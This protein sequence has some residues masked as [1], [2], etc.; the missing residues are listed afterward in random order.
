MNKGTIHRLSVPWVKP[1]SSKGCKSAGIR[2]SVAAPT[3]VAR[4]AIP[5]AMRC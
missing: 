1:L 4:M 2:G 3:S 5:Q